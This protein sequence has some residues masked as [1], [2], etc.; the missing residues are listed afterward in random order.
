MEDFER[1]FTLQELIP[2]RSLARLKKALM[3]M[4]MQNFSL[5][6]INEK[7]LI[8]NSQGVD[9]VKIALTPELEPVGFLLFEAH[10][11]ELAESAVNFILELMQ[12]N[13]RY[14]MAS[15][16]HLQVSQA[17]FEELKVKNNELEASRQQYKEL[18][19]SLEVRVHEQL[20]IIEDSQRQLYEAEKLASIGQLAAGVAHEI[21]NPIGFISSN[22]NTAVDYLTDLSAIITPFLSNDEQIIKSTP[23]DKNEARF[24]L[25]DFKNL[26]L[27]SQDGAK[28]VAAIVTNLKAFSNVDQSEE[29]QVD[30]ANNIEQ[31]SRVF[32]NSVNKDVLL[33]TDINPLE[34]TLCRPAHINQLILNLLHNASNAI[35]AQDKI[36]LGCNMQNGQINLWVADTGKGMDKETQR[37]AFDPFYT[38]EEVGSGT[39]LGLTV[40]RDIVKAHQ[41]EI[42]ID[43]ELGKGTRVV[44]TLPLIKKSIA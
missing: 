36:T 22:L 32:L 3:Q 29:A 14:Q 37:K 8:D 38:T 6:D 20:K 39:G 43:S 12:T 18:S 2:E 9:L 13:W 26:L 24:L 30:L 31:V 11:I 28:R 10:H 4:G 34:K 42:Q 19:E 25:D 27:E 40:S 15:D 44:I 1:T 33:E 41:G 5:I 7:V 17:D 21:N 23:I 35:Q 16:I